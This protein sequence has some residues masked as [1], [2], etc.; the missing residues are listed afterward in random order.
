MV[1]QRI[2]RLL[3][4]AVPVRVLYM[5]YA[6][7]ECNDLIFGVSLVD[8]AQARTLTDGEIPKIVRICVQEVDRRGLESEGIYRV[9]AVVRK[10]SAAKLT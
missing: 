6:V 3:E 8:Y 7:G 10:L 2:P 4:R 1:S 5:N 9:C